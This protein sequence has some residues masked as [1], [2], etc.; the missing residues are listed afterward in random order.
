V[1]VHVCACV[2]VCVCVCV[3]ACVYVCVC[4]C[5]CVCARTGKY[6]AFINRK[7][8]YSAV[9]DSTKQTLSDSNPCSTV[10]VC[11]HRQVRCLHRPQGRLLRCGGVHRQPWGRISHR[12]H[13][14]RQ[15]RA[16]VHLQSGRL[17]VCGRCDA[18]FW[19]ASQCVPGVCVRAFVCV[20]ACMYKH[21]RVRMCVH[22]FVC[23]CVL[24]RVRMCVYVR[25]CACA[26]V[27]VHVTVLTLLHI[28]CLNCNF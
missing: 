21:T 16:S 19:G 6:G 4:V 5:M 11:A 15:C 23:M 7:D 2:Y 22:V 20:C 8:A 14:P 24:V 27:C 1:R 26:Y 28:S 13:Q 3:C 18:H 25:V 17:L 9:V 12:K 10:C